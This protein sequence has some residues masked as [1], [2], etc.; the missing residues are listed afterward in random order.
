M[1]NEG[2]KVIVLS[3]K[4]N[5]YAVYLPADNLKGWIKKDYVKLIKI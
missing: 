1:V 3:E 5:F 4:E 2:K